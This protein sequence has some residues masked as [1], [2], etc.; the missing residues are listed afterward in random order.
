MNPSKLFLLSCALLIAPFAQANFTP[1]VTPV[2]RDFKLVGDF[3]DGHADFTLTAIAQVENPRGG[4]LDLLSGT[5]A[6]T[7]LGA[8]PKWNVARGAKSFRPGLRSQ[9]RISHPNQIQRRRP[10]ERRLER[11][12]F[13][14]RAQ[15]PC[16]QSC[17]QGLA[18]DT[19][20]QFAGAA[21]PERTGNDFAS[22]L[23]SD[24]AVKLSWK[25]DAARSRGQTFLRRRNALANQRQPRPDAADRRCSIS[26]SCRAN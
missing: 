25:E 4:S 24:G 21:R 2:L 17:L 22:Y 20:F 1:V 11:G 26:R 15:R 12:R 5:V 19:Q 3:H 7:K 6:L 8:H 13:P 9:R 18:A 16:S 10:S 14:G 23:P